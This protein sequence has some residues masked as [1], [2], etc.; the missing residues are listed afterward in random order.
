MVKTYQL[1]QHFRLGGERFDIKNQAGQVDYR[2]EGSFL[3]L[4]KT[5]TIF[6]SH[7]QT[8]SQISQELL[9][10]LPRFTVTL[11]DGQAFTIRK[12]LTFFRDR[13]EFDNLPLVV[14]G[15]IW[16]WDFVLKDQAGQEVA[17]ISKEVFRLTSTYQLTIFDESYTDLV[18]SLAV[19]IDYVEMVESRS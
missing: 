15:D 18:V 7:G 13:Y 10:F 12:Q 6:D 2:V 8:V 3:K 19:A 14:E 17:Q 4:P 1:K 5:F 11:A 9:S 16:D